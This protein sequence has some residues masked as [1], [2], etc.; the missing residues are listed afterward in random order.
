VANQQE[1]GTSGEGA[2]L[3]LLPQSPQ[4]TISSWTP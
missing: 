1:P 2:R 4:A 3:L